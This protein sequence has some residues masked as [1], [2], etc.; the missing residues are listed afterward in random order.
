MALRHPVREVLTPDPDGVVTAFATSQ[1]YKPGTVS[2]WLNG[3][4]K[5]AA[6]DDGFDENEDGTTIDL[7]EPPLA[8]DSVVAEY[9]PA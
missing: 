4:R 7:K 2:L 8:G 3:V 6:W 9:E 1:P 5:V